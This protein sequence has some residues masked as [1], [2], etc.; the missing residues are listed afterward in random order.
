MP[1]AGNGVGPS[2]L[3][4]SSV[5]SM[6]PKQVG[7]LQWPKI[8]LVPELTTTVS[9]VE[10]APVLAGG[11]GGALSV[12][13]GVGVTFWRTVVDGMGTVGSMMTLGVLNVAIGGV[14]PGVPGV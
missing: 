14:V 11:G 12:C 7:Q 1:T 13:A 10:A 5:Q 4:P 8:E 3:L 6:P 2:G 9:V